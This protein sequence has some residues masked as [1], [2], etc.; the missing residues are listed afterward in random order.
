MISP[1]SQKLD[2]I[3]DVLLLKVEFIKVIKIF[4]E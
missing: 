1:Q 2:D 4:T 3:F